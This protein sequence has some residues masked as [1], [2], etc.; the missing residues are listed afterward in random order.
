M[1]TIY[2]GYIMAKKLIGAGEEVGIRPI[3]FGMPSGD[4]VYAKH[5]ADVQCHTEFPHHD[6]WYGHMSDIT[7]LAATKLPH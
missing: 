1:P 5:Y 6:G 4:L 7:E 3:L 2:G